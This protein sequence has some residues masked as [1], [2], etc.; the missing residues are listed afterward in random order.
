MQLLIILVIAGVIGYLLAGS[1]YG[2]K[3]E[4]TTG[5]IGRLGCQLID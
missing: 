5:K 2:D 1:R 4:Q 3:I